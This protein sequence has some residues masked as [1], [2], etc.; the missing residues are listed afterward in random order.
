VLE[1]AESGHRVVHCCASDVPFELLTGAGA[2]AIAVD[3]AL[4]GKAELDSI[5]ELIDAGRS[6]WLGVAPARDAEISLDSLRRKVGSLWDRLGFADDLRA[7]AI[8]VSPAC[9]MAGASPDYVRRVMR[10][11]NE[12]ARS[13]AE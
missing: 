6:I 4:L 12:T 2:D 10:L 8:V 3:F 11:L 5:G 7:D 1:A 13:L 9:G